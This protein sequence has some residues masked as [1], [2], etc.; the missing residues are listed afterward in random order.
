M[1]VEYLTIQDVSQNAGIEGNHAGCAA[2]C[3]CPNK[4]QIEGMAGFFRV[5]GPYLIPC[6]WKGLFF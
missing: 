2:H 6:G 3:N 5:G 4:M 1:V